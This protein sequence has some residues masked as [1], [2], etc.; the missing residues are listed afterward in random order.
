MTVPYP[1]PT[2]GQTLTLSGVYDGPWRPKAASLKGVTIDARKA[3]IRGLF[4]PGAGGEGLTIIGGTWTGLRLDRVAGLTIKD[5]DLVGPGAED[6]R[7][8]DGYGVFVNGGSGVMISGLRASGYKSGVVISRVDG[9]EVTGCGLSRMRSDGVQIAESRN[10][11]IA[12]NVIHGTRILGDEHPDGIQIWSRP[13][14]PPT[15]DIVIEDNLIVGETQGISGFNHVRAEVNDG[16][17]DRITIRRNRVVGGYP[18]GIAL[19]EG[20]DCIVT[21]NAVSTYPGS[22]WRASINLVRCERTVR[23][24]NTVAAGAGKPSADDPS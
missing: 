2:P 22:R 3:E 24:G 17:F 21:D 7:L 1:T 13:T 8:A 10:G 9:F 15:A 12:G 6:A 23:D 18:H 19:V 16:G 4:Y 11:R 20:R 14:S 5:V